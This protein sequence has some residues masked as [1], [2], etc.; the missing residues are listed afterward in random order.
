MVDCGGMHD[1]WDA[2]YAYSPN[3]KAPWPENIEHY[4]VYGEPMLSGKPVFSSKLLRF[5]N[6]IH[7]DDSEDRRVA[8]TELVENICAGCIGTVIFISADNA[9]IP[10]DG[11]RDFFNS[12][13]GTTTRLVSLGDGIDSES[14]APSDLISFMLRVLGLEDPANSGA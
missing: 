13:S 8:F 2:L 3:H 5:Y 12:L 1:P 7:K 4:P 14:S 11:W 9:R 10:P 6:D